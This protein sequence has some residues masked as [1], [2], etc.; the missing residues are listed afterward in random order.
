MKSIVTAAS[1]FMLFSLQAQVTNSSAV[2]RTDTATTEAVARALADMAVENTDNSLSV[3]EEVTKA[4]EYSYKAQKTAWL[5][6]FRASGNINSF[7]N[8]RSNIN[9]LTGQ[10][11]YPRYNI[12]VSVPFGIFVNYP[13]QTKAQFHN[14]QAQ[15]ESL[16]MAKQNL[17]LEVITRYYNYVRTQKLYELQEEVLQDVEFATKKT[18][19]RFS[20]GEVNL[21]AYT[22]ASARYNAERGTKVTLERDLMVAK[23]E[24]EM[25]LG[26]P[27][28]TA[29]IKARAVRRTPLPRK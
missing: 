7:S 22:A 23:A 1:L 28:N 20:K 13:K 26:M 5:D 3:Q 15:V 25:L 14:Y 16:R 9:E 6:N 11:F 8:N 19:E 18:E 2:N 12:G 29:L 21:D 10:A 17:R 27:L 24:M 4:S